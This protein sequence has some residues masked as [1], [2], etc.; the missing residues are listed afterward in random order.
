MRAAWWIEVLGPKGW[1]PICVERSRESARYT[2]RF[3]KEIPASVPLKVRVS[4]A[5]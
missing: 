1:V 4:R 2:S 3:V 5:R